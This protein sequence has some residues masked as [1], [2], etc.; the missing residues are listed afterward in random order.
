MLHKCQV[1][2]CEYSM[3]SHGRMEDHDNDIINPDSNNMH[4]IFFFFFFFFFSFLVF[5]W[6]VEV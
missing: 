5:F 3:T 2:Q 6:V 4:N 1:R